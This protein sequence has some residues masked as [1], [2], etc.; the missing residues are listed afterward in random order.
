MTPSWDCGPFKKDNKVLD[1]IKNDIG[2]DI[3]KWLE[4]TLHVMT[5]AAVVIPV[6]IL[7]M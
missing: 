2:G 3:P 6:I 1:L 7:L 4:D 5:T